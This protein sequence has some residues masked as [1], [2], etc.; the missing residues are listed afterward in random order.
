MQK[1]AYPNHTN[2][3]FAYDAANRLTEV[4]NSVAFNFSVPLERFAYQ[5]DAVGNRL[6]VTNGWG[7]SKKYTYDPLYELTSLA[8]SFADPDCDGPDDVLAKYSYDAVGNRTTLTQ[9]R[10][11]VPYTYDADDRLLQAGTGTFTYDADG[12]QPP[13]LDCDFISFD[14]SLRCGKP[15]GLRNGICE[16]Q[17]LTTTATATAFFNLL[18]EAFRTYTN[19]VAASLPAVL[20]ENGPDGNISYNYGLNR[21]SETSSNFNYFYQYDG[22]GSVVGLT[23]WLDG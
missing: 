10:V 20:Q 23:D 12:N 13:Q 14:L 2:I 15:S 17:V 8:K 6:S 11:V 19:D 5:L 16:Q 4:R 22:L 1:I 18:G 7:F 21:I 3:Q 9:G